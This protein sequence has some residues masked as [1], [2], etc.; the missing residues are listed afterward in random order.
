MNYQDPAPPTVAEPVASSAGPTPAKMRRAV[1][2]A[3]LIAVLVIGAVVGFDLFRKQMMASFFASQAPP[4]VTV[5]NETV[6]TASVAQ[7][8]SAIG[9]IAAVH[10]VMISPETAGSVTA[11]AFVAGQP[12]K[13]GD[14]IVQLNDATERAELD[15]FRAQQKLAEVALQ[16]AR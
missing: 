2:W 9:S 10:Q 3:L 8:L 15:G 7:T 4:P 11:I 6:T 5:S 13:A 1:L 14:L 16:R 12:V